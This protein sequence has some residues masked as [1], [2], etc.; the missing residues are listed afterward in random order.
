LNIQAQLHAPFV[1]RT[2]KAQFTVNQV[3][4]WV[5][6]PRQVAARIR[7]RVDARTGA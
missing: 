1:A 6:A 3:S 4:F 7:G 2:H 5:A